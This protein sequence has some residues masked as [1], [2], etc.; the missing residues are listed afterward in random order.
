M[1]ARSAIS[2]PESL[3]CQRV[4]RVEMRMDQVCKI[5]RNVVGHTNSLEVVLLTPEERDG[6]IFLVSRNISKIHKIV[7]LGAT[8]DFEGLMRCFAEK[9]DIR[10]NRIDRLFT[11]IPAGKIS[12]DRFHR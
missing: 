2:A 12:R 4:R 9:W 10:P 7:R 8:N 6:T 1:T 11:R 3:L 5:A